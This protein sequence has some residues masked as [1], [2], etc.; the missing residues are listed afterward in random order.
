MTVSKEKKKSKKSYIIALF[1]FLA[2]F[3][4]LIYSGISENTIY[5]VN[6]A[7]ALALD[8]GKL[9]NARMF[10]IVEGDNFDDGTGHITFRLADKDNTEK[11]MQIHYHGVLPD[12]FKTGAEVIVEGAYAPETETFNAKTVMTKCPSKYKKI[13]EDEKLNKG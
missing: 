7:E 4:G 6:V 8:P 5:F 11:V 2:G 12:T 10:G 9:T 1:L 3:G 13:R